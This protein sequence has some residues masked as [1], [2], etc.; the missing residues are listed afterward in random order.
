MAVPKRL[1]KKASSRNAVKRV[2]REAWR[3]T[4]SLNGV[5][6]PNCGT[7]V[8][9]QSLPVFQSQAQL[10]TLIRADLDK[11]FSQFATFNAESE[12]PLALHG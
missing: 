8:K 2:C 12:R 9:L 4:I 5:T 3:K 11:L 7:L 10:K 1:L 6:M